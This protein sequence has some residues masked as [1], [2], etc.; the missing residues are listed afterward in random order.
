MIPISKHFVIL[1]ISFTVVRDKTLVQWI[2]HLQ[3]RRRGQS[4]R[5]HREPYLRRSLF[6]GRYFISVS[7]YYF[8][9]H[10][11]IQ[12][13][14]SLA[15]PRWTM[16]HSL[17]GKKKLKSYFLYVKVHIFWEGHKDM[18]RCQENISRYLLSSKVFCGTFQH[19][20]MALS[21]YM[22]FIFANNWFWN[23]TN[24]LWSYHSTSLAK[25]SPCIIRDHQ[26]RVD[27]R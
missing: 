11:L 23:K 6:D 2:Q 8:S 19:I 18:T 27:R 22:N 13:G 12:L 10:I 7:S 21:E 1:V 24:Y 5:G 16:H 25:S 14:Y 4:G 15:R 17:W 3:R 26:K 20:F 9:S